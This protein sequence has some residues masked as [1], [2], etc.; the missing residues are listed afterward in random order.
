MGTKPWRDSSAVASRPR[1]DRQSCRV[2]GIA[3]A[4][5]LPHAGYGQPH[6]ADISEAVRR[7]KIAYTEALAEFQA[8]EAGA[9]LPAYEGR[10][11][12]PTEAHVAELR[13]LIN[14]ISQVIEQ[15]QRAA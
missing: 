15:S 7:L 9:A 14:E 13:N 11:E 4:G 2:S 1:P 10:L 5:P 8:V 12:Q 6:R 3:K